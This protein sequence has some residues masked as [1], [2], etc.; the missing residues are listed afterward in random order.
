MGK[1]VRDTVYAVSAWPYIGGLEV[2]VTRAVPFTSVEGVET[3]MPVRI[4]VYKARW[5]DTK[6]INNL[7]EHFFTLNRLNLDNLIK[8]F[9]GEK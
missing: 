5:D 3:K 9:K 4:H 1:Y 6:R 7:K 8:F 2:K